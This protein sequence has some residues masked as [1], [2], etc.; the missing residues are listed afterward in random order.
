MNLTIE[1]EF[2]EFRKYHI[3]IYNVYFHILCGFF[4]MSFLFLSAKKIAITLLVLYT[5]FLLLT[6]SNGVLISYF[7]VDNVLS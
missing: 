3:N 4:L 6:I 7:V 5:F 2:N 1:K